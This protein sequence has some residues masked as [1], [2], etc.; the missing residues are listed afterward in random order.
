M[1]EATANT[2]ARQFGVR[3]LEGYGAT[4]CSPAITVNTPLN[5]RFGSAGQVPAGHRIQVRA[6]RRR[7]R[8]RAPVGARPQHHARLFEPGSP[9]KNSWPQDGWYDTGDIARVDEDGFLYILGRLKRFAKVSG[10]M[11]SLTAAE[12]ALAGAFPQYGLRFQIAVLARPDADRGEA[13]VA[14]ANDQR[15]QHG[16]NPRRH[17]SQGT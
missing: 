16:R 9:T 8:G 10:E 2:W 3:V 6:G 13:L 14:V 4:E 17:Q 12:E 5:P 7:G 15:L 1:Q 11:V